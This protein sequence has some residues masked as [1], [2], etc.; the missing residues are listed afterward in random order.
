MEIESFNQLAGVFGALAK[1]PVVWDKTIENGKLV[2]R[3]GFDW[4][5]AAWQHSTKKGYDNN[6]FVEL[7]KRCFANLTQT[8]NSNVSSLLDKRQMRVLDTSQKLDT[9]DVDWKQQSA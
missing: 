4:V 9:A 7:K 3:K 1:S 5:S 2:K 8:G 6:H